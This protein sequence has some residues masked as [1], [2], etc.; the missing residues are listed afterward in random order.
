MRVVVLFSWA[1]GVLLA[2]SPL[3]RAQAAV[4]AQAVKTPAAVQTQ[5]PAQTP[6]A[7][8]IVAKNLAARG[9][10]AKLRGLSTMKMTGTVSAQGMEMPITV[11]TKRP[12]RMRQETT[13]QGMRL[14]SAFDGERAW[15]INPMMG[16]PDPRDLSG[17]Q[18]DNLKDQSTFDGPLVGYKERGDTLEVV[19]AADVA[20]SKA[21]K[22]KLSRGNGRTMFIYIDATT[23]LEREWSTSVEQNGMMLDVETL[24]SDYG[25]TPEGV[26]VARTLHTA[27][28]G[29]E[30]GIL[31]VQ[32]VEFN[33]PIDDA[34]FRKPQQQ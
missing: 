32:T 19:G 9:G 3:A 28:G 18:A 10:E 14:V 17:P 6:T 12:N 21:W 13:V 20:G 31:K 33:V 22:L 16:S 2:A 25:P 23:F 4:Q 1:L 30:Q 27:V 26:M 29:H 7:D 34:A 11:M 5:A 15:V 24:M 8:E